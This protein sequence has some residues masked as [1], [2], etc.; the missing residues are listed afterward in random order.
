MLFPNNPLTKDKII[1]LFYPETPLESVDNIFHQ[2]ISNIRSALKPDSNTRIETETKKAKTSRSKEHKENASEPSFIIYEDKLLK[3][4]PDFIYRVDA[5]EFNRLF[6][7]AGSSEAGE[8]KRIEYCKKAIDLYK[9][10]LLAGYYEPWCEDLRQ[11]Y[12][13][14]FISLCG[15]LIG[16]LKKRKMYE[17]IALYSDKLIQIDKLNENGYL[18][19]IEAYVKLN[20]INRAREKFSQ[21]LKTYEDELGEKPPKEVLEKIKKMLM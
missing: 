11:E 4:N 13:N 21:M 19:L 17:E 12:S 14:K 15:E 7:L 3:L 6:K 8:D 5:L 10:E 2:T 18:N 20:S 1:D 16:S 9:G